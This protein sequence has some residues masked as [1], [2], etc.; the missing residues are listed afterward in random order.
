VPSREPAAERPPLIVLY[1][2]AWGPWPDVDRLASGIG[3]ELT[4]DRRRLPEACAVVFHVPTFTAIERAVKYPGQIYLNHL[5]SDDAAYALAT[6]S[7]RP[8]ASTRTF[9]IWSGRCGTTAS[10]AP[11]RCCA[12]AVRRMPFA[13]A[14]PLGHS[15]ARG[16]TRCNG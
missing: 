1:N 8:A 14:G 16:L 2:S 5:A 15:A 4:V 3:C 11:A 7:G 6:S 9:S 12:S 10:T 13:A